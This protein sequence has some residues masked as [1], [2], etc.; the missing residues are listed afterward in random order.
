M[1][2]AK[3]ITSRGRLREDSQCAKILAALRLADGNWLEMP[4]LVRASGSYNIHTRI[5]ELRQRWG[6]DIENH[7]D[8]SVR[9]HISKYRLIHK[10]G[11][12]C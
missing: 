6:H 2:P 9:P 7:T 5:D 10:E 4:A 11:S 12:L 1:I 8:T 3:H